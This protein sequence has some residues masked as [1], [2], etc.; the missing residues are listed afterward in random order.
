[1]PPLFPPL[2]RDFLRLTRFWNLAIVAITQFCTGV[3]LLDASLWQDMRLWLLMVSTTAIAAA[4]YIINDYYDIKID[5]INKP[6]RVVV[7]KSITRRYALFFHSVLNF[8]A[9]GVGGFLHWRVGV[10]HFFC[11]FLL[12]W[13]SNQLK[14]KPFVGNLSVALLTALTVELIAIFY[15]ASQPLITVYAAFA[16]FMTLVR[17]IVK[18]MEDWRGDATFGCQTLPILWGLRKTRNLIYVLLALFFISVVSLNLIYAALPTPYFIFFISTP[19]VVLAYR[20]ARA[21]TVAQFRQLSLL[22]KIIMLLGIL[23][24]AFVR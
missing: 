2:L 7:G 13:Y 17:E 1:M 22:C 19:L 20:L 12:W 11:A 6:E 14:R 15:Q 4:G 23:S 10:I 24:M 9:I 3:F 21:D 18:D 16:F 8:F 5:L